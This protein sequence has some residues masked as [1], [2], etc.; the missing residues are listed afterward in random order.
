LEDLKC[1]R[2]S[3]KVNVKKAL[4]HAI[5]VCSQNKKLEIIKQEL[6]DGN[7][8]NFDALA[9][10]LS[11]EKVILGIS[12]K[13]LPLRNSRGM[14]RK[15]I[16][17]F[18][19]DAMVGTAYQ[20][21]DFS[22]C[23][24]LTCER[25]LAILKNSPNLKRLNVSHCQQLELHEA[26]RFPQF[27]RK[28]FSHFN[29]I[30][31]YCRYL[32][33]LNLSGI[34]NLEKIEP[35]TEFKELRVLNAS[36]CKN[37]KS[38][39]LNAPSLTH[40]WSK[41]CE[42]LQAIRLTTSRLQRLDIEK[43]SSLSYLSI[44]DTLLPIAASEPEPLVS[45]RYFTIN[46]QASHICHL[47]K[48]TLSENSHTHHSFYHQFPFLLSLPL[49]GFHREFVDELGGFLQ[50]QLDIRSL[51]ATKRRKLAEILQNTLYEYRKKGE[52]LFKFIRDPI[53]KDLAI[54]ALQLAQNEG[55]K[56]NQPLIKQLIQT[57]KDKNNSVETTAFLWELLL[58][59]N[60]RGWKITFPTQIELL[61]MIRSSPTLQRVGAQVY[62]AALE[63]GGQK[64]Q[65]EIELVTQGL[66]E[67]TVSF[68]SQL[69]QK[70]E[71]K[72]ETTL[73]SMSILQQL[74][75]LDSEDPSNRLEAIEKFYVMLLAKKIDPKP[76]VIQK[77][78]QRL[79]D[80]D[81][82]VRKATLQA[83]RLLVQF[84]KNR[85]VRFCLL[86]GLGY[87]SRNEKRS[88]LERIGGKEEAKEFGFLLGAFKLENPILEQPI[89]QLI[90]EIIV[91]WPEERIHL[92]NQL[93][94][95]SAL[96]IKEDGQ[97]AFW[98]AI[99]EIFSKMAITSIQ[100][101]TLVQAF[102]TEN[103][104]LKIVALKTICYFIEK[105][106]IDIPPEFSKFFPLF[107]KQE[108]IFIKGLAYEAFN[109][110]LKKG[111]AFVSSQMDIEF[112]Q[113]A[114]NEPYD[115]IRK[116][117][118]KHLRYILE[119]GWE[120]LPDLVEKLRLSV[121]Y[122][123][124]SESQCPM[125][126]DKAHIY[127]FLLRC[128]GYQLFFDL[129]AKEALS[130]SWE[131]GFIEQEAVLALKKCKCALTDLIAGPNGIW[132]TEIIKKTIREGWKPSQEIIEEI[133]S[134]CIHKVDLR[135][136]F[137]TILAELWFQGSLPENI[138]M[139]LNK[140]CENKEGQPSIKQTVL[141]IYSS[142]LM[143]LK[144]GCYIP[145][146]LEERLKAS[147]KDSDNEIS[148]EAFKT[149][150]QL[151]SRKNLFT[152]LKLQF[153][154]LFD[155]SSNEV[156]IDGFELIP[157]LSP[158]GRRKFEKKNERSFKKRLA[159]QLSSNKEKKQPIANTSQTFNFFKLDE[160]FD[161]NN[162][163]C[164]GSFKNEWGEECFPRE[165]YGYG[166]CA[167][168]ATVGRKYDGIYRWKEND[169]EARRAFA[170]ELKN[171]LDKREKDILDAFQEF[172]V[173]LVE[174]KSAEL[175]MNKKLLINSEEIKGLIEHHCGF[176]E[177][178]EKKMREWNLIRIENLIAI[179]DKL[180]KK[181]TQWKELLFTFLDIDN[182]EYSDI[183]WRKKCSDRLGSL[184][185]FFKKHPE[186]S[187]IVKEKYTELKG[188]REQ[189][190][191]LKDEIKVAR[192]KLCQNEN[193][194]KAYLNAILNDNYWFVTDEIKIMAFLHNLSVEI[195]AA[196]NDEI[197][198]ANTF[199]NHGLKR[200]VIFQTHSSSGRGHH[201]WH[202][203]VK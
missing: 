193:L 47:T 197:Y 43:C 76:E 27:V 35:E 92:I 138:P 30:A 159:K 57:T 59:L 73:P 42:N 31:T 99:K 15:E 112:M 49:D 132:F 164:P 136:N 170:N 12:F 160:Y 134:H 200:R 181:S 147:L 26:S 71:N 196:F 161:F 55:W 153:E 53:F 198:K 125:D 180:R 169:K 105:D 18:I 8:E 154:T 152:E 203:K 155:Q 129:I 117:A 7:K 174:T 85:K 61:Q 202:C 110:A 176:I 109:H 60:K 19:L 127:V 140:L 22:H 186:V 33:G 64:P 79:N 90:F 194:K 5:T 171:A 41:E 141:N 40:F 24:E 13:D 80:S 190:A 172:L 81:V 175:G 48:L 182:L 142:L 29:T 118:N 114:L 32:E 95:E 173:S 98:K 158:I 166:A 25:L 100:I 144:R 65:K 150:T 97:K 91:Q 104:L 183:E 151:L 128:N 50:K 184:T 102:N 28:E 2:E 69:K 46:V 108:D 119:R 157:Q 167:L 83:V 192:K 185:Q 54:N 84:T 89:W 103:R 9:E 39:T 111:Q 67:E 70:E 58:Q 44:T 56:C 168:H 21:L 74:D 17:I 78:C 36:F 121:N 122:S 130:N 75:A 4:N 189:L 115:F 133:V 106:D 20:I 124:T 11:K 93:Q 120:P 149:L 72:D 34:T 77:L 188:C 135:E 191:L 156:E 14:G 131:R 201:F 23:Q 63:S 86:H 62:H 88:V 177:A 165:T 51:K 37:L 139:R 126:N 45:L 148:K 96:I 178:T 82:F 143:I 1:W 94:K 199:N 3:P 146:M 68:S 107:L 101:K 179:S 145:P 6:I 163:I 162:G 52:N 66:I 137:E 87:E 16:E 113:S 10:D 187:Q 123:Y 195:Y 38:V 116:Q